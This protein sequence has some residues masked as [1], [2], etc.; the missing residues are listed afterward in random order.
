[1]S[2]ALA[3]V[4]RALDVDPESVFA[5]AQTQLAKLAFRR[6]PSTAADLLGT[7]AAR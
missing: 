6:V 2:H 1:V 5:L 3:V 7:R 4:G